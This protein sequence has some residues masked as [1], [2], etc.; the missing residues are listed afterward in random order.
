MN[1]YM[2]KN[3]MSGGCEEEGRMKGTNAKVDKEGERGVCGGGGGGWGGG[4]SKRSGHG[5][6]GTSLSESSVSSGGDGEET[7]WRTGAHWGSASASGSDHYRHCAPLDVYECTNQ[8]H[9]YRSSM[10]S[11]SIIQIEPESRHFGPLISLRLPSIFVRGGKGGRH[12]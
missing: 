11:E 7:H 10:Q 12:Y 9:H 4:G 1:K 8:R 6:G 5:S 3:E 2:N